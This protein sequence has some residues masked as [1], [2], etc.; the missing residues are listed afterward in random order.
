MGNPSL[1][2]VSRI[3]YTE[4]DN[5]INNTKKAITQRFDF[6]NA[7]VEFE[8]DQKNKVIKIHT[9]DEGRMKSVQEMFISAAVK[10]GFDVRCFDFQDIE[11]ARH[12]ALGNV[13]R[14]VKLRDGLPADLA[15]QIVK[16]IKDS[17]LKVQASIQGEEVRLS[18]KQIDDLRQCMAMLTAAG[19]PQP[20]QFVNMKS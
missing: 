16:I 7:K 19:L 5:A 18:G 13:K 3:N 1:D 17:K 8:V 12:G 15:K 9:D 10:R 11:A 14:E 20:L 4:L 6:R 2:I